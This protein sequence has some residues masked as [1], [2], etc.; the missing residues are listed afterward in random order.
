V[1]REE[2]LPGRVVRSGPSEGCSKDTGE[3]MKLAVVE[4][5]DGRL[6]DMGSETVDTAGESRMGGS[7]VTGCAVESSSNGC[8][9]SLNQ[10]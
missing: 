5:V 8:Q 3:V 4:E 6:S 10:V 1:A 2:V 9:R 7:D